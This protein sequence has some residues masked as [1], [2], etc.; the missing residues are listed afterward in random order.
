MELLTG[1]GPPFNST[2]GQPGQCYK[3]LNTGD[4]YKCCQ[5]IDIHTPH[6]DQAAEYRWKLHIEGDEQA[7]L[8]ETDETKRSFVK[9]KDSIK[10]NLS[11]SDPTKSDYVS[12]IIRQESLPDKFPYYKE[13]T[14]DITF[15]GNIDGKE[16]VT[17]GPDASNIYL[18]KVSDLSPKPEELL[19]AVVCLSSGMNDVITEDYMTILDSSGNYTIENM[20]FVIADKDAINKEGINNVEGLNVQIPSNGTYFSMMG[21]DYIASVSNLIIKPIDRDLLPKGVAYIDEVY[22]KNEVYS[23]DEVD[24]KSVFVVNAVG[25]VLDSTYAEILD[26]YISGKVVCISRARYAGDT[27]RALYIL[28]SMSPSGNNIYFTRIMLEN[29]SVEYVVMTP[30]NG[31]KITTFDSPNILYMTFSNIIPA[32]GSGIML[33]STT[34]G[35]H[36][37]FKIT[38]DDSG[39]ISATEVTE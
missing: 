12:G 18:V 36:K 1:F 8:A 16:L 28:T 10:A 35:S 4:I 38:V 2:P 24:A 20:I 6:F 22:S 29:R 15:D 25:T 31:N 30:S 5:A 13:P 27:F 32:A 21:S 7:D 3:D 23:K 26:A 19:N 37:T 11:Q 39:T 33:D 14:I 9:N 17:I 34:S